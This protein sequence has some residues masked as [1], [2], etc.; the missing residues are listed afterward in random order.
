MAIPPTMYMGL[1]ISPSGLV[2][3][4]EALENTSR[5]PQGVTAWVSG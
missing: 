3:Q 5:W 4:P 2:F 1:Y